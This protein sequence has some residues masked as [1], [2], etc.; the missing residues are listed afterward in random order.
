MEWPRFLVMVVT[1]LPSPID[2]ASRPQRIL[3][4]AWAD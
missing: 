3:A 1:D 4:R 2:H